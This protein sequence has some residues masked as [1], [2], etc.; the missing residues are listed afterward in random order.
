[1]TWHVGRA[2]KRAYDSRLGLLIALGGRSWHAVF[3]CITCLFQHCV[4]WDCRMLNVSLGRSTN[5]GDSQ[6]HVSGRV[7]V[8]TCQ[9]VAYVSHHIPNPVP[10]ALFSVELQDTRRGSRTGRESRPADPGPT[11]WP[12]PKP[13]PQCARYFIHHRSSG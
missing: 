11:Q 4:G 2:I 8:A 10:C 6:R 13:K 1:M 9:P 12:K 5:L 7:S 3:Q